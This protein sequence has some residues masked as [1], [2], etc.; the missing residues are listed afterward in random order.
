MIGE[1]L[2]ADMARAG[3]EM[4]A[5]VIGDSVRFTPGHNGIDESVASCSGEVVVSEAE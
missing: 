2:D 5:Y 1:D 4:L 3:V